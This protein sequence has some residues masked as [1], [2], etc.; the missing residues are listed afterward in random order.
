MMIKESKKI[1]F[2]C[3]VEDYVF[4]KNACSYFGTTISTL[5]RTFIGQLR[6]ADWAYLID[7]QIQ[8]YLYLSCI[9][10]KD[11]LDLSCISF[12]DIWE[13]SGSD[14]SARYVLMSGLVPPLC[15]PCAS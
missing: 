12:M 13:R 3:S 5:M 2:F 9:S 7:D 15:D 6:A 11:Y 14:V 4:L 10:F 1:E 8:D